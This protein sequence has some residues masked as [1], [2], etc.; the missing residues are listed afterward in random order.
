MT[1]HTYAHKAINSRAQ[2]LSQALVKRRAHF[3][4]KEAVV[5]R[6]CGLGRA[7]SVLLIAIVVVAVVVVVEIVIAMMDIVEFLAAATSHCRVMHTTFY[8]AVST[9]AVSS[10]GRQLASA[11]R[12]I[13]VVAVAAVA[14]AVAVA[15][16]AITIPAAIARLAV[17]SQ[18]TEHV[19]RHMRMTLAKV[20]RTKLG[21]VIKV[22]VVQ[23][24]Q[25]VVAIVQQA[26]NVVVAEQRRP[27]CVVVL[28]TGHVVCNLMC[29]CCGCAA[30]V[31]VC[32][33]L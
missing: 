27:C 17:P 11:Q 26:G 23:R 5:Q 2:L 9:R 1:R 14:V 4:R 16:V 24:L 29:M 13:V 19:H 6:I 18:R 12:I 20:A 8:M 10:V 21:N 33:C 15:V 7:H 31:C 3:D 28:R 25:H 30:G 32:A 22:A